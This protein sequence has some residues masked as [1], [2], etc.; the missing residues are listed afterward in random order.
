MNQA[1][2]DDEVGGRHLGLDLE[3]LDA[4]VANNSLRQGPI[5][6]DG[7]CR[8]DFGFSVCAEHDVG[9]VAFDKLEGCGCNLVE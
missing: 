4:K 1:T 9:M 7:R 6:G 3:P 5:R 2:I 8:C